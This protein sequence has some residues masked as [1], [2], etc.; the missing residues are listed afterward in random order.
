M[1]GDSTLDVLNFVQ[2]I[3]STSSSN[4]HYRSCRVMSSSTTYYF[5]VLTYVARKNDGRCTGT[6]YL[7]RVLV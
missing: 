6:S 4:L 7:P 3:A 5:E 1:C 2:Y